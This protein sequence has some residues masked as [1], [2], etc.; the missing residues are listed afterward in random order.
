MK[1]F[2]KVALVSVFVLM[3]MSLTACRNEGGTVQGI[4]DYVIYVG[5]T[6]ATSGDF[7]FVG[8]PFNAGIEAYFHRVNNQGG[9]HGRRIE[10]VHHDDG[11][12]PV[13]GLAFTEAL[14]HDDRVFALVGHFGTPTIGATLDLIKSEGIPAVYFAAGIGALY[15]QNAD[16]IANGRGLFPVQPIFITEGR[17][18]AARVVEE[19]DA[20]TIG[21]IF[22]SD[23]AGHDMLRGIRYQLTERLGDGFNLVE[24]QIA[25]L[26]ADVTSAVLSMYAAD[27]DVVIVATIQATFIIVANAISTS[28]LNVPIFTSY[29]SADPMA[30]VGIAADYNG[31]D[32]TFPIYT[33]AWLDVV[34]HLSD[35]LDFIAGM[36]EFG[37]AELAMSAFAMAGWI[38]G[39]T[40]V[41]GLRATDANNITWESFIDA[42]ENTM[43]NLPMANVIDFS[44][45]RRTGTEDLALLRANMETLEWETIHSLESLDAIMQR[46]GR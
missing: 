46:L 29:V 40:F 31:N 25:P 12:N 7:A 6:A 15:N 44:N 13:S 41:Q 21:V 34:T 16:T 5:N 24:H 4:T 36:E 10:L 14:I 37:Q 8:G 17:I 23:E 20:Q 28:S 1:K 18:L 27:V 30:L 39:S 42:M 45:G 38:A 2:V 11:F 26:Q 19:Y 3:L 35:A 43:I 32:R 22:T 33:T 9:V